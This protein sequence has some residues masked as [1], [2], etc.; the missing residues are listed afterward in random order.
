[1]TSDRTQ[2][3]SESQEDYLEAILALESEGA[4][5]AVAAIAARKG[6]SMPSVNGALKRLE[7][8]E[9]VRH[10]RYDYVQLTPSGRRRAQGV[11]GRHDLLRRFLSEVLGVSEKV[12]EADACAIEHHVSSATVEALTAFVGRRP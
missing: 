3:L 7:R 8:L 4:P 12:A 1:M 5:V 9:L 10:G 6:V 11:A 2:R